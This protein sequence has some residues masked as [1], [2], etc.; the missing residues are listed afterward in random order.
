MQLHPISVERHDTCVFRLPQQPSCNKEG[1][2]YAAAMAFNERLRQARDAKGFTGEVL[3]EHIG[4]T[5]ATIS[6]WEKGTHEPGIEQIKGLCNVL[7]VSA[8]WLF[9]RDT[10]DLPPDAI[11]E[12][13]AYAQLGLE[14]RRK[15]KMMRRAMFSTV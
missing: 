3:G 4:V 11:E 2:S 14:D 10:V 8:D 5:R 9:E 12:A 1:G 13:R 7:E 6:H 15:W